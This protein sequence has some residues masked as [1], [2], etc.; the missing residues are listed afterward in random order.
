MDKIYLLSYLIMKR[1]RHQ[2]RGERQ[3]EKTLILSLLNVILSFTL[4]S[5]M[6]DLVEIF[7]VSCEVV[8][9]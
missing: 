1:G 3:R 9:S 7:I 8:I 2:A 4:Y 5:L 6:R